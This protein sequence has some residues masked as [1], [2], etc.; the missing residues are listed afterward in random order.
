[1]VKNVA[2]HAKIWNSLKF[3]KFANEFRPVL[4]K[5][6]PKIWWTENA[7]I[8][9]SW[10]S[11]ECPFHWNEWIAVPVNHFHFALSISLTF[12]KSNNAINFFTLF[13]FH[14]NISLT[15]RK[16]INAIK[17]FSQYLTLTLSIF[18]TLRKSINA[19]KLF[20]GI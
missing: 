11:W 17:L 19:I 8:T 5:S 1:L 2:L 9:M 6:K 10:M 18:L 16:S 13:N 4:S 12:H 3:C 14:F 15:F 7:F 20:H